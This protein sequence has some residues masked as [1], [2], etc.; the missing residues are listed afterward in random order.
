M[1]ISNTVMYTQIEHIYTGVL[2]DELGDSMLSCDHEGP[3]MVY[4]TKLY[5]T[6]DATQFHAFGRVISGTCKTIH[7]S[8]DCHMMTVYSSV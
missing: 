7:A 5:P 8:H 3:L 4:V 6:Q 2:E 1:C